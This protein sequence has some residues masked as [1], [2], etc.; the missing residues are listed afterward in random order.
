[1][2]KVY[3]INLRNIYFLYCSGI[4]FNQALTRMRRTKKKINKV[5]LDVDPCFN[6]PNFQY[7]ISQ[8]HAVARLVYVLKSLNEKYERNKQRRKNF[9]HT[10]VERIFEDFPLLVVTFQLVARMIRFQ[11]Q[12]FDDFLRSAFPPEAAADERMTEEERSVKRRSK[13]VSKSLLYSPLMTLFEALRS[14]LH[15]TPHNLPHLFTLFALS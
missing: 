12:Y 2:K 3:N 6:V 4:A 13:K 7:R 8:F 11:Q 5:S 1:M 9:C 14:S 15:L 10:A